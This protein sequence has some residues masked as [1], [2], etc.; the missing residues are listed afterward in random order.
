[1]TIQELEQAALERIAEYK[2]QGNERECP[3]IAIK[4]LGADLNEENRA[5]RTEVDQLQEMSTCA[6]CGCVMD[7]VR[8]GKHQC[9]CCDL[10]ASA[11]QEAAREIIQYI[12][13]QGMIDAGTSPSNQYLIYEIDDSDIAELKQRY[14]LEG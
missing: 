6:V 9:R 1:M 4:A 10:V 3:Y 14:G 7:L 13:D 8:P 11:R 12:I 2:D 5:L